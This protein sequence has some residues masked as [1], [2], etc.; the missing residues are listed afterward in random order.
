MFFRF[1]LDKGRFI[2]VLLIF[3][4]YFVN[5]FFLKIRYSYLV[6]LSRG[7]LQWLNRI[8]DEISDLQSLFNEGT[9][10]CYRK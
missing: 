5:L 10:R 4:A 3:V 2:T 7:K 8:V 9:V 6:V 1:P